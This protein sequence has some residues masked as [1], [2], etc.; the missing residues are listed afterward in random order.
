MACKTRDHIFVVS[1][2][3]SNVTGKCS[4][5]SMNCGTMNMIYLISRYVDHLL[6][7]TKGLIIKL[8]LG[9]FIIMQ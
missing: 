8:F 2:F 9:N 6:S 5:K 3:T 7:Y 1:T 4:G